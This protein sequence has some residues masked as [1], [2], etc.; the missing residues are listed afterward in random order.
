MSKVSMKEGWLE[1]NIIY[2]SGREEW[3]FSDSKPSYIKE[4]Y[5]ASEDNKITFIPGK[6]KRIFYFEADG[7][8]LEYE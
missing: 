6:V 2:S 8:D 5:V 4:V 3:L 1:L 7:V